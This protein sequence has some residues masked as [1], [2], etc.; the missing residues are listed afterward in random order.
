M[1]TTLALLLKAS[2]SVASMPFLQGAVLKQLVHVSD[3]H[4]DGR[5][6][7]CITTMPVIH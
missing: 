4:A 1:I 6:A 7:D 5:T 3:R 2:F